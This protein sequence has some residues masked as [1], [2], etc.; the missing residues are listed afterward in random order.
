MTKKEFCEKYNLTEDQFSGKE[1][2]GYLDLSSLTTLPEGCSLTAGGDLDLSSLTTLPEG[3][4][5]TA[6]GRLDLSSLTTLPEGCSLTAGGY[7][8]L[9]SLTKSPKGFKKSDHERQTVINVFTWQGG[10]YIK[11]DGIFSEVLHKRGN[12]FKIKQIG[13]PKEYYLVTD[14]EK[15]AHGD[16]VKKAKEDLAFKIIAEK[17]KKD[18]IKPNT[19]ISIQYYRIVTGACEAGVKAWM[20]HNGITKDKIKAKD[21]LPLLKKTNAYG[22]ERFEKLYQ[23]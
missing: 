19:V 2:V 14:G 13:K 11:S 12:V 9:S 8:D 5:L 16:T 15:Y 6:G 21:L 4:S 22:Y 18:P 7:L 17:L 20:E 23:A 3:C 1:K 10:K